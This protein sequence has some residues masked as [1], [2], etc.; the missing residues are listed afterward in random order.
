MSCFISLPRFQADQ[1]DFMLWWLCLHH[2]Q[3][4]ASGLRRLPGLRW[5]DHVLR[6]FGRPLSDFTGTVVF[7]NLVDQYLPWL[8]R[9][10]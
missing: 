6:N 8:Q 7:V 3:I 1:I 2:D 10:K 9:D 4:P 5:E